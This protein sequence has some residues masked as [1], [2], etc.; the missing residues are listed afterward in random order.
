MAAEALLREFIA[1]WEAVDLVRRKE[2]LIALIESAWVSGG[3]I[4]AIKLR[5]PFTYLARHAT[6]AEIDAEHFLMTRDIRKM[7]S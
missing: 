5:S 6:N 3:T 7:V 1:D 2:L 4:K